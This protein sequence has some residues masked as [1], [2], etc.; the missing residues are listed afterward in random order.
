MCTEFPRRLVHSKL[1]LEK[2]TRIL[3]HNVL[4]VWAIDIHYIHGSSCAKRGHKNS[5]LHSTPY[6]FGTR[7]SDKSTNQITEKSNVVPSLNHSAKTLNKYDK[8]Y[9]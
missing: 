5:T 8:K 9:R 6:D 2:C 7:L 4:H 1:T 3:G